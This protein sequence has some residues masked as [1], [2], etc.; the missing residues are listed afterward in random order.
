VGERKAAAMNANQLKSKIVEA[1]DR[2]VTAERAMEAALKEI[3]E[4]PRTEK[5]IISR[6]LSAA[7]AELKAARQH[8]TDLEQVIGSED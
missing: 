5:S 4:A 2:L 7:F 1:R 8:L 6:A 3:G